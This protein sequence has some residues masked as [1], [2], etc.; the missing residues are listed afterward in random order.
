MRTQFDI[1][2][3]PQGPAEQSV[4]LM[5]AAEAVG[6]DGVWVAD[7]QSIFRDA[8]VTLALGALRTERLML[9]TGVTNPVTRHPA[10]IASSIATI[11]ELSGGRA[12]LGIGT[13]FSAVRTVGLKP[14]SLKALEEATLALRALMAGQT[15]R[16]QGNEMRMTWAT[17]PVPIYFAASGPKSLH[18]AGRVADGVLFQVGCEPALIR[19]A[20]DGVRAGAQEAGR[21]PSDVKLC[22]RLGCSV[23]RNGQT[24]REE[25]RP[26]AAAAAETVF[27]SNPEETLPPDL[28]SDLKALQE[29]Y[30]YYQ[31]VS[32]Q[33]SH[34]SLVTDRIVDAM[35]IAGT[36]EEAIP[37]FR[38]ILE[39]GVDRVVIPLTTREPVALLRTLA[40][41]V[42]PHL[43]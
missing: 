3:L 23:S 32:Q 40:E 31:H 36:P 33:A 4:Q 24:A 37:R 17:R 30:N 29:H 16:Y 7:S 20:I 38:A 34:G 8:F 11:D 22:V 19:R 35:V 12:V 43:V 9:A 10:A 5:V 1:G 25:A 27:Q 21:D 14:A 41:D 18:R 39:L 2:V 26:Y 42:I 6:F 15:A 28:V 13:G